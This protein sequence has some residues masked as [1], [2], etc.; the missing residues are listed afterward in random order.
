V[1]T[2]NRTT[3]KP[4][5]PCAPARRSTRSWQRSDLSYGPARSIPLDGADRSRL[6]R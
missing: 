6:I 3:T 1:A 5:P 2:T 4:A